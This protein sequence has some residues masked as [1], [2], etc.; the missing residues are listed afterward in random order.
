MFRQFTLS[1]LLLASIIGVTAAQA[2]PAMPK[3][4]DQKAIDRYVEIFRPWELV[5]PPVDPSGPLH[6]ADV[7][8]FDPQPDPPRSLPETEVIAEKR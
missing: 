3:L 6:V 1:T 2:A 8:D 5:G 7:G 4:E